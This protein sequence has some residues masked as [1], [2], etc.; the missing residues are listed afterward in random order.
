MVSDTSQQTGEIAGFAEQQAKSMTQLTAEIQQMDLNTQ[1]N[2]AMVEQS[3]AAAR[4]L[5]DQSTLMT[6]IVAKFKLERREQLRPP[7]E[8]GQINRRGPAAPKAVNW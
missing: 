8:R 7:G 4:G 2:A 3:N 6:R 1:Q 5:S